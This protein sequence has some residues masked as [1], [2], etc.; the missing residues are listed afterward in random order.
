MQLQDESQLYYP[1][2]KMSDSEGYIFYDSI[3]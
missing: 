3:M 2:W 1:K